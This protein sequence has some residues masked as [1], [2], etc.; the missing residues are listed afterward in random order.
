[1]ADCWAIGVIIY[2]LWKRKLPFIKEG[3]KDPIE[4]KIRKDMG[5]RGQYMFSNKADC[6]GDI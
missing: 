2:Y 5:E 4:K 3:M 6:V 1:M